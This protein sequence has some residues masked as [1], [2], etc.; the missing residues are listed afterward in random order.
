[1]ID[2]RYHLVSIVAVLVALT[3]GLILG[4]TKLNGAVLDNLNGRV[5]GLRKDKQDLRT[6]LRQTQDQVANAERVLKLELPLL[7]G[8]RLDGQRVA[9]L[10]TPGT[11]DNLRADAMSVL[12]QAGA[13]VTVSVRIS[14][15][16]VDPAKDATLRTVVSGLDTTGGA[17]PSGNGARQAAEMLA[18]ALLDR[19][20]ESNGSTRDAE[21][22]LTA[23][24]RAGLV[25]VDG[26]IDNTGVAGLALVLTGP[27]EKD[28]TEAARKG[29]QIL[30]TLAAALD[31]HGGGTVIGGPFAATAN[32]G[33][34]TAA[35]AAADLRRQVSTV[36]SV[37]S[38]V[39]QVETVFALAAELRGNSVTWGAGPG[40]TPPVFSAATS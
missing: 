36:D 16:Y 21:R 35:R 24:Q 14:P 37:E 27:G 10:S 18:A 23:F 2:F 8:G 12:L 17:T 31:G 19:P 5:D 25:Q 29:D 26:K 11:P 7:V 6:E 22:V 20:G 38:P 34:L 9:V 4:T 30:L 13:T 1:M 15:E 33:P 28:R 32:E 39:G 3:V 40:T